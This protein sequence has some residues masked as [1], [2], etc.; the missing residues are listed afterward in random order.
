MDKNQHFETAQ[1]T[2][3]AYG[4]L[5]IGSAVSAQADWGAKNIKGLAKS[6]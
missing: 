3:S 5:T 2:E 1:L 4:G 6:G